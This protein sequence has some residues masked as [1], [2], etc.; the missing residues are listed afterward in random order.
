MKSLLLVGALLFAPMVN[1]EID[2]EEPEIVVVESEGETETET[3]EVEEEPKEEVVEEKEEP[4]EEVAE[5]EDSDE[6]EKTTIA[7]I[8]GVAETLEWW[9]TFLATLGISVGGL[10]LSSIIALIVVALRSIANSMKLKKSKM[11]TLEDV[12]DAVLKEVSNCVKKEMDASVVPM[13][14][15]VEKTLV[16][17]KDLQKVITKIVALSQENSPASRLAILECIAS[18]GVADKSV[19]EDAKESIEEEIKTEQEI[20]DDANKKL[21]DII[22]ET[23]IKE[24]PKNE[25]EMEE[26][27]KGL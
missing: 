25:N 15:Q 5:V 14:E 18:L 1:E 20:K 3:P 19:I 22:T 13:I 10:S 27:L 24:E 12:Q 6:D 26:Y 9:K 23:E 2:N 17:T 21:D 7:I 4:K 16:N 11:K 8:E